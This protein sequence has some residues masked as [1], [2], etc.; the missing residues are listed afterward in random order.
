[1]GQLILLVIDRDIGRITLLRV[2]SLLRGF[3]VA[4]TIL[5]ILI[6]LV[7]MAMIVL[8]MIKHF[9]QI[10][11]VFRILMAINI[12]VECNLIWEELHI[13]RSLS[14]IHIDHIQI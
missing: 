1:M 8:T 2:L 7:E 9:S 5:G 4:L 13:D 11:S 12:V 10:M 3:L 14:M 6:F